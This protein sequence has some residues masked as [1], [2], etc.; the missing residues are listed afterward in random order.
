MW[1][2]TVLGIFWELLL[3][4]SIMISNGRFSFLSSPNYKKISWFTEVSRV[5]GRDPIVSMCL[6]VV[7]TEVSRTLEI[8]YCRLDSWGF[9]SL[10]LCSTPHN[11]GSL[12]RLLHKL[13]LYTEL[14][15]VLLFCLFSRSAQNRTQSHGKHSRACSQLIKR[16]FL[17]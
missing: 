17:N 1:P 8:L 13:K 11:C 3:L 15:W 9:A 10:S 6:I 5:L 16:D 2:D 4:H 14:A 7:S 12:S